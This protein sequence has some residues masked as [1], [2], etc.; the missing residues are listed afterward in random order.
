MFKKKAKDKVLDFILWR[1]AEQFYEKEIA[2][3]VG[4]SKSMVNLVMAQLLKEGW[5]EIEEKGRL[6]LFRADLGLIKVRNYKK[7]LTIDK[8]EKLRRYLKNKAEKLILF[9]S[10]AKG[11]DLV[12]SDLDIL[13]VSNQ[14]LD[15]KKIR[16]LLPNNRLG[17]VIIKTADEF[18]ELRNK[19]KV[20]YQAIMR[21]E[22]L[23]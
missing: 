15:L 11:E 4:I 23:I 12:A 17:Q 22:N 14:K 13:V 19:N 20:F 16:R 9:G 5:V 2:E 21:G 10:A 3:K 8:L 7:N 1:P 18:R 6:N